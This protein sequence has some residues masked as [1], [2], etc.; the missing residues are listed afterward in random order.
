MENNCKCC[1]KGYY[2]CTY[3]NHWCCP[4]GYYKN[5]FIVF[6]GAK[7]S[8]NFGCSLEAK[9]HCVENKLWQIQVVPIDQGSNALSLVNSYSKEG[10]KT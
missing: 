3:K 4:L 6:N 1:P 2:E 10:D 5:L 8:A 9:K 7:I